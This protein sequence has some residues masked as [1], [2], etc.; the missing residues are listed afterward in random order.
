[1]VAQAG[2]PERFYRAHDAPLTALD[3]SFDGEYVATGQDACPSA[4][5][6]DAPVIVWRAP[7]MAQEFHLLGLTRRI[8]FLTFSPDGALLAAASA[9][10]ALCIWDVRTSEVVYVKRQGLP[11]TTDG[12]GFI[13][14]GPVEHPPARTAGK[15]AYTLAFAVHSGVYL[16]VLTYDLRALQVSP[17]PAAL[18]PNIQSPLPHQRRPGP[19]QRPL[20]LMIAVQDGCSAVRVSSGRVPALVHLRDNLWSAPG[21][22]H[23]IRRARYVHY[24][25]IRRWFPRASIQDSCSS[26]DRQRALCRECSLAVLALVGRCIQRRWRRLG[27]CVCGLCGSWSWRSNHVAAHR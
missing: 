17:V 26:S 25:A 13:A 15:P 4:P 16:A 19:T 3:V 23:D 20:R 7:A 9:D 27:A 14:W 8:M 2:R 5:G 18:A 24:S 21:T 22:R 11:G 12:V 10:N 6:G 1:M